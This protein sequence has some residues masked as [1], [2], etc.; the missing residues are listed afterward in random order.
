MKLLAMQV[1]PWIVFLGFVLHFTLL[2]KMTRDVNEKAEKK[3]GILSVLIGLKTGMI[4][5]NHK[6]YLPE[7]KVPM[8]FRI[9]TFVVLGILIYA[10]MYLR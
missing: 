6:K 3:T 10:F 8:Y 7:S 9:N 5:I 4:L 2:V 1:V